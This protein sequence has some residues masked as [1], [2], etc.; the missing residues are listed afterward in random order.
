[1]VNCV[2]IISQQGHTSSAAQLCLNYDE[3]GYDDWYLPSG[4]EAYYLNEILDDLNDSLSHN[5][6]KEVTFKGRYW[7]SSETH[8]CWAT[9]YYFGG[10]LDSF[11]N[12]DDYYWTR[13]IRKF[14]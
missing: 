3:N 1:M 12:K 7:T 11:S 4:R 2:S 9:S 5:I 10:S 8:D 6:E 13:A 14:E